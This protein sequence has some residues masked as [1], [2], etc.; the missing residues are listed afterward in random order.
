MN[1]TNQPTQ[2]EIEAAKEWLSSFQEDIISSLSKAAAKR[3]GL[4]PEDS[5][6]WAESEYK[7]I[8]SEGTPFVFDDLEQLSTDWVAEIVVLTAH[9][10]GGV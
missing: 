4:S 1:N 10:H 9:I 7:K 2:Q 6:T 3:L 5:R 8:T